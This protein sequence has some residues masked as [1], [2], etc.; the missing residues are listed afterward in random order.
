MIL[1]I[2]CY[3]SFVYNLCDIIESLGFEYQCILHDKITIDDIESLKPH[4]II[5]SPGPKHPKDYTDIINIIH[6]FKEKIPIFGVCLGHQII[7]YSFKAE[8]FH[9]YPSHGKSDEVIHYGASFF[10]NIPNEFFVARYHSLCV[11]E[12]N[13]P[14]ELEIIA[15]NKSNL[16][17]ALKHKNYPIYSV[18][19]HPESILTEH[20]KIMMLNFLEHLA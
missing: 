13:F 1:V 7:A 12:E 18:Q 16:V 15:R 8:I 20:G 17:M 14:N 9:S 10:K 2:N 3:D 6:H 11:S 4:A 19:F 5:L